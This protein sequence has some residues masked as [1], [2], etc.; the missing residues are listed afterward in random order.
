MRFV[1]VR[2]GEINA[3][4]AKVYSGRSDEPLNER[5]R[6]QAIAAA[7]QV[8]ALG[9][10]ALFSSPLRRTLETSRV[11]GEKTSCPVRISDAF[12]EIRM[13]PWEGLSEM[14]VEERYPVEFAVWNR[15]PADL[16]IEG[17]ETLAELQ[18]RALNGLADIVDLSPDAGCVAVVSHVAIIRVILL[19]S[20]RRP[21]NDYKKIDVP[22]ASPVVLEFGID[23][24]RNA[25]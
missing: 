16:R 3:N 6:A 20:A 12:N 1:L 8:H 21:L 19:H 25:A 5:G 10:K 4:L 2:H 7:E 13:G 17:R 18:Q 23:D 9:I 15:T 22:N 14:E 24:L 11:I